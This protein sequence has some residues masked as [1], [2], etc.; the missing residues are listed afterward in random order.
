[1]HWHSTTDGKISAWIANDPS[2]SDKNLV[3]FGP[4]TP[5]FCRCIV[6][7]RLEAGLCHAFLVQDLLM[8]AINLFI[9]IM[10]LL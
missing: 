6:S 3:N 9:V 7:G 10:Y 8:N 2:T 4:V 5:E 1:M